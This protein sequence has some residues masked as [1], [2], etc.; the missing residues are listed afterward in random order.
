[1][2][3]LLPLLFLPLA[4]AARDIRF[5]RIEAPEDG[6]SRFFVVQGESIT[7]SDLPRL[8]VS[9]KRCAVSADAVQLRLALERPTKDKPLPADAPAVDLPAGTE[10][11][12]VILLPKEGKGPFSVQAQSVAAPNDAARAGGMVWLN[13]FPRTLLVRLGGPVVQ[14]PPGQGRMV[15]PGVK[16][17]DSYPV[18]IDMAPPKAD[19]EPDPL[20]RAT[21]VRSQTGRHYLFVLPDEARI[22]PRIVAVPDVEAPPVDPSLA[23]G[24]GASGTKGGQSGQGA[25]RP[26]TGTK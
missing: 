6:P 20:V 10:D 3:P 16:P 14:V 7:E 22:T 24:P 25:H 8:A 9:R 13:L 21:W 4:L 12:L 11:L 17:G 18:Y 2:R 23:L 19:E 15:V 1:M 26:A 5:L